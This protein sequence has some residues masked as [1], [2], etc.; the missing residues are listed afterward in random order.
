MGRSTV[1]QAAIACSRS[2][3]SGH[4][5]KPCRV[6]QNGVEKVFQLVNFADAGQNKQPYA[7]VHEGIEDK[8]EDIQKGE[9]KK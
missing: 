2:S 3:A 8:S 9:N 7:T 4:R 5:V 1:R 6:K